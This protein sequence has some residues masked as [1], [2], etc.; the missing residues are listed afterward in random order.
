M[1][2]YRSQYRMLLLY[3]ALSVPL[4]VWGAIRALGENGNSPLDWVSIT[5]GPRADF[6]AFRQEF[7]NGDVVLASWDGA[8]VDNARLDEIVQSLRDSRELCLADGS[9]PFELVMT[10]RSLLSAL[11]SPPIELPRSAAIHR[12][13]GSLIGPD[14]QT[15]SLVAVLRPEAL[16]NRRQ[17]VQQIRDTI[18]RIDDVEANQIHLAGP[19]IDGLAVDEASRQSLDRYAFPS[20]VVVLICCWWC[21]GSLRDAVL[22]FAIALFSQAATLAAVSYCG[23]TMSALLIVMP[24]LVQ[25]LAVSGGIHLVNYF[26]SLPT[27]TPADS[28]AAR[29]LAGAWLPSTLSSL[30]T[31]IGMMSL[32]V[33]GLAP[34]RAFGAYGAFGVF[35]GWAL[36]LL[37]VPGTLAFWARRVTHLPEQDLSTPSTSNRSDGF[38]RS[39]ATVVREQHLVIT[40]TA[41]IMMAGLGYGLTHVDASVRIETL[42]G[43]D[44]RII[45]D[46]AWIES[47]VGPLVPIEIL[48]DVSADSPLTTRD[49]A[50]LL[51]RLH[52]ELDTQPVIA[53]QTS[54]LTFLP[55]M[56]RDPGVSTEEFQTQ[57]NSRLDDL[58]PQ[59]AAVKMLSETPAGESWR[60]TAR[61]SALAPIHYGQL[62]TD[63]RQRLKPVVCDRNGEPLAGVSLRLTGIMPLV[64]HIQDRLIDDL[65]ASFLSAF[66]VIFVTMTIVQGGLVT[67]AVSMVS[68]LFPTVILFGA[69]GWTRVPMDIGS[70]MTAGVALGMAIDN[71]LHFLTF[72]RR[73][74]SDGQ[75]RADAIDAA[76]L[77]CGPAMVQG[78]V[79][80]ACGLAVFALSPFMPTCRFAWMMCGL[81]AAA[82]AGDLIVLPA[83]LAGPLGRWFEDNQSLPDETGVTWTP[84]APIT[85]E[86]IDL[87]VVDAR[88][89][90][91][92]AP[93]IR[94][95]A[96]EARD[97]HRRVA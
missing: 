81:L 36:T 79:V 88:H 47:R 77:H 55:R 20:A 26:R 12:L 15:T 92:H 3:L 52:R 91:A 1:H 70:I 45:R 48:V 32:C 27:D 78:T 51:S 50:A 53:G 28:A 34:I 72:F 10:G 4:V 6:E 87:H 58:R 35:V 61:V 65:F 46:Y 7:G 41:V 16:V 63:L 9:S 5:Y 54:A 62:L 37:L 76:F 84:V 69:L 96:S 71:T 13:T 56:V 40:T 14:Q 49:R 23:E 2:E 73:G 95:V 42:F 57:L 97:D 43:P 83:L 80:C 18:A 59:F 67:G 24:P 85:D 11:T 17:V 74:L 93:T 75:S 38:W 21:L 94:F 82:L 90:A 25:V 19:V 66:A 29:T 39:F 64:H 31:I 22:V 68:N 89:S 44:S 8:T 60:I 86:G 30:T 33:S